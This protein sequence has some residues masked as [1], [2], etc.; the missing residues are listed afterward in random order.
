M[1]EQP[2]AG[3]RRSL[4]DVDPW[5]WAAEEPAASPLDT[6]GIPVTAI[7][8]AHNAQ[9]WLAPALASLRALTRRPDRWLAVDT[10]SDDD[11]A[12]LLRDSGL[13]DQV[14][15]GEPTDGFGTAVQ[16]ALDAA[17]PRPGEWLWLLHDD[18]TVDPDA[19]QQ[20]LAGHLTHPEAD[21]LGPKLLQ[22]HRGDGPARLSELGVSIADS[23]RRELDLEPGEIDQGQHTAR[24]VLAVSTCGPL[25]RR[26]VYAGLGGLAPELPVFRDGVDLGW[27][28]TAAGHQVW[29]CPDARIT[30]R[31]AG[32]TG[33]RTSGL[34]GDDPHRTDR[35]LAL[36]TVAAHHAGGWASLKLV[37]GGWLRALGYLLGKAPALAGAELAAVGDFV[38]NPRTRSLRDRIPAPA[39]AETAADVARLR[40][41]RWS[42]LRSAADGVRE[43]LP[44][45]GSARGPEQGTSI[46][47]LTGDDF[48]GGT[49]PDR[50]SLWTNPTAVLTLVLTLTAL[51][52]G[53]TLIG[54][55]G[56]ASPWLLPARSTL[57]DAYAA[58]LDPIVGAPGLSAPPWLGFTALFST[59]SF[60]QPVLLVAL[61]LLFVVPVAALAAQPLLRRT[62]ADP[63]VRVA[64]TVLYALLVALLAAVNRGLVAPLAVA[65]F[66]P[67]LAVA[68]RALLL[69]RT[70]GPESW[71]AAWATGLLLTVLI[72]FYPPV[73]A[74]ALLGGLVAAVLVRRERAR[75][76]RLLVAGLVPLVLL[77]PWWPAILNGWTRLFVG[78]DAGLGGVEAEPAWRLLLGLT[79]GAGAPV[80]WV[81]AIFFGGI[82]LWGLIG[83][84]LRSA[85]PALW[86]SIGTA[87]AAFAL[88]VLLSRQLATA[89]PQGTRVR[90][91]PVA[92]LL[93]G[94]AA[95]V[96]AGALG[97][98]LVPAALGRRSFG[99]AHLGTLL[100]VVLT[101]AAV[102]TG[103]VW[104]ALLGAHG[105]VHRESGSTL[106]PYLRN[107]M[108]APAQTRVLAIR[109]QGPSMS[110]SLLAGDQLRLGDADRGLAFGGSGT[111]Q[112]HT[113]GVVA[114]LVAGNGD[115][116]V[117]DDLAGLAVSHVW[118]SGASEVE[119]ARINNTPGLGTASGDEAVTVWTVP[120]T[121]GRW[122]VTG[123]QPVV[124]DAR[125]GTAA[126]DLVA[127]GGPRQ[128]VLHEPTDPRWRV[129]FNGNAL[130][131]RTAVDRTSFDLPGGPGRLEVRLA[132][133]WRG[134]LALA[135]LIGLVLV[136][137]LAAP[138]LAGARQRRQ[139]RLGLTEPESVAA[140]AV[141]AERAAPD[142]ETEPAPKRQE[143]S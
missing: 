4:G 135:Q 139:E 127:A 84:G 64:A 60:G 73:G 111:M 88:A 85:S 131:G 107:A 86:A 119:K 38:G 129:T 18:L 69:R 44:G 138:S 75:V 102:G 7:L 57:A 43:Y 21:L 31:Q 11:T 76:L 2:E 56:P 114:R 59:L 1:P 20:L 45:R 42:G 142:A 110:W 93:I 8:V 13:F 41:G 112:Q 12:A 82:W 137:L 61:G 136:A 98:D 51:F 33:L 87:L 37:L 106:A 28:A 89:L 134:W 74:L 23:G 125:A 108:N 80:F 19:L 14:I 6:T 124:L 65:V 24:R 128:L 95:L 103:A 25:I 99:L 5:A 47:D 70:T 96:Y 49:D 140:R 16:R 94:F 62:I 35:E 141:R 81:A 63:R 79:P 32:R 3:A 34:I 104:W 121:T 46:D 52:A 91:E 54:P 78:P 133:P 53:R 77:A 118:I 90:P 66:T 27:R 67:L 15:D 9:V 72:A 26:E 39:S 115:E 100:V 130:P 126:V 55:G 132:D 48:A 122:V 22:P 116:Q 92:L 36:R 117:A 29:T 71:R 68:V 58:Y 30:H 40:P 109:I 97:L 10:G 50:S 17:E 113:R 101:A 143:V 105:P 83:V 120:Q 123:E